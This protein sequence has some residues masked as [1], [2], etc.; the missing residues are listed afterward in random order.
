MKDIRASWKPAIPNI[1]SPSLV[2]GRFSEIISSKTVIES[3][4]VNPIVTF[5]LCSPVSLDGENRPKFEK[6]PALPS[7]RQAELQRVIIVEMAQ[8]TR[9]N[10]KANEVPNDD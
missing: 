6:L 2:F 7:V 5:S 8:H 9:C 10:H 3:K 4:L 1:G